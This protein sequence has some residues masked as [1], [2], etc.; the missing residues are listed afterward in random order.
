MEETVEREIPPAQLQAYEAWLDSPSASTPDG[1]EMRIA[2]QLARQ[3]GRSPIKVIRA[4]RGQRGQETL[5]PIV[6]AAVAADPSIEFWQDGHVR[7]LR[8]RAVL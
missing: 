4:A 7:R 5:T 3:L 1:P 2:W 8:F 6:E